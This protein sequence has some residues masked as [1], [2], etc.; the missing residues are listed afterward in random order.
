MKL[1]QRQLAKKR[2]EHML[3]RGMSTQ[4]AFDHFVTG[5]AKKN[6]ED[7]DGN[8]FDFF[9][10]FLDENSFGFFKFFTRLPLDVDG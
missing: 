5:K 3:E 6:Q 4:G 10:Y 9:F 8:D 2:S 7:N 1:R